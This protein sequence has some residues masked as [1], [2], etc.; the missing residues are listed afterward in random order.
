MTQMTLGR[1]AGIDPSW[2]SHIESGRINPTW[3]NVRRIADGLEI[4]LGDLADAAQR[5]E[6]DPLTLKARPGPPVSSPTPSRRR[7]KLPRRTK[8]SEDPDDWIEAL[9][10]LRDLAE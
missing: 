4:P 1:K 5:N 6:G 3:A 10:T 2:I 9:I 8:P 7:P